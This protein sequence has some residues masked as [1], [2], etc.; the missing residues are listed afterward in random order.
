MGLNQLP[1]T[2]TDP[3]LLIA[4]LSGITSVAASN[5][6]P[7]YGQATT[8]HGLARRSDGTAWAWGKNDTGQLGNGT[9]DGTSPSSSYHPAP[10]QVLGIN[11]V[12]QVAAG[13]Q[14]S[15][16]LRNDGMVWAWGYN[17][18]GELGNGTTT[19]SDSPVQVSGLSGVV[20]IAA[21]SRFSLAL[22][23]DGT[24]W[25]WGKNDYGQL[26]DGTTTSRSSPVQVSG[27][28]GA[29]AVA[30]GW[31]HSLAL[32]SNG[33]VEAWG[34]N[35]SGQLGNGTTTDSH[36]PV[37]VSGLS[38]VVSLAAGSSYS[39]A[40]Q[41]GGTAWSWGDNTDGQLGNASFANSSL[42][43]QVSI[44]S[45]VV[46][47]G[48]GSMDPGFP[49]QSLG[50]ESLA[51][52]ALGTVWAWGLNND[53]QIGNGHPY[54]PGPWDYNTPQ[55][56]V[57]RS[58]GNFT[59]AAQPAG[60]G[61]GPQPG[62]GPTPGPGGQ[63]MLGFTPID[64]L[65]TSAYCTC[66]PINDATGNFFH[67]FT[68]VSIPGRGLPLS[69]VRTY[70]TLSASQSG[71]LG[72]G[73]TH[74]YNVFLT[75]DTSGNVTVH[76]ENGDLITFSP[77][78]S[79]Y[80]APSRVQGTLVKN[81]DGSF[82]LNRKN[83]THLTFTAAGQL[84]KEVDRN[85]YATNLAYQNN[86][87]S[88]VTDPSGRSLA[89]SY[90]SNGLLSQIVDP[91]SRKVSFAYDTN[92]NLTQVTDANSGVTKFTYD[93]AH[94]L[95]T[96]TDPNNGLLQNQYDS[97]GRIIKQIDPLNHVTTLSYQSGQTTVTHPN[98]NITVE[99][100]QNNALVLRT[101]GYGT[102]EA[103]SWSYSY[104]STS[105]GIT[106]VTDPNGRVTADTWD[107]SGNLLSAVD[108]LSRKT[109]YMYDSMNDLL[110]KTDALN[111]TTSYTYDGNGNL[112]TIA[113]PL[114]GTS[115]TATT[116][117]QYD[118]S[119]PGDAVKMTDPAGKLWQ[120]SYDQYGDRAKKVDP[121]TDTTTYAY[122]SVGRM[123]SEVSPR[124][125]ATGSNP[126]SYTTTY[127][128]DPLGDLTV[129]VDPLNHQTKN[130]YDPNR[131]LTSAA[132]GNN[133]ATNYTY[134]ADN[135]QTQITRAD[136]T[137]MKTAYDSNGNLG[138][139]TNGLNNAVSYKYNALNHRI[140]MTDP[141]NRITK[142]GYDGA[143]NR[144]SATDPQGRVT[145]YVYDGDNEVI[146]IAYGDGKTA[147]VSLSYDADGQ[148]L[149]MADGSGTSTYQFDSLHRVSQTKN[150]AGQT[151]QYGY[152]LNGHLSSVVY[153]G[154]SN[155]VTRG[156][157]DAGR[158]QSI[159]D[160]LHHT[161][162]FTYDPD[163]DLVSEGYPNGVAASFSY[164]AADRLMSITDSKGS[165]QLLSLSYT[166]D[167]ANQLT[168]E[169]SQTYAYNAIDQLTGSTLGKTT[170]SY[171]YSAA[172]DVTQAGTATMA[173][174]VADQLSKWS[175]SIKNF[176]TFAYDQDGNRASKTDASNN[177]TTYSFD[178][179]N[180]LTGYGSSAQYTY[181]GDG[182][183]A[184]KTVSGTSENF[185]W[186][187]SGSLPVLVQDG[188][189]SYLADDRGLPVEQITSSGALYY[190][191]QDQLGS[192]R[193]VTDSSGAIA[194]SYTYDAYGNVTNSTGSVANPF[195]YAGQYADSESKMV[196]LRA[197]YY[198]P[199]TEAFV[200]RDA[201]TAL[202]R[203]PY[204]Y[205]RDNPLD[206]SDPAGLG[207]VGFCVT[208]AAGFVA[209]GFVQGCVVTANL[210]EFGWT[211]THTI[212]SPGQGATPPAPANGYGPGLQTPSWSVSGQ[213]QASNADHVSDL[214][215]KFLY[216]GG[217]VGEGV[218]VGVGGFIGSSDCG[219]IVG[220]D[221]GV[222]L[223]GGLPA[224]VHGGYSWTTYGTF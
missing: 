186:D 90:G 139:Q 130:T 110:S 97:T 210:Q 12:I 6:L 216:A 211:V 113:T 133:Q 46:Q 80:Q 176:L 223:G 143:G 221:A 127:S 181:N 60:C 207:T 101:D 118:P 98:G 47:V 196:Y 214:G 147:A 34:R 24:V 201:A 18:D 164:D 64:E 167:S 20:A 137:T 4:N 5:G 43:V 105:L 142:Y 169:N 217:S 9:D 96:M 117:Y 208:F 23:S 70:N 48:T 30:A 66:Y 1:N 11:G 53:G 16:A 122:D 55:Q 172:D 39:L 93:S 31:F 145:S 157:D 61:T 22:K 170:T 72:Y 25:A 179:A 132:N 54:N 37:Q 125:N 174:D 129:V 74:S 108:P 67:L 183:R 193:L 213:V 76:E 212:D 84:T 57:S 205:V 219:P 107:A 13:A 79:S 104:D 154:G 8:G 199:S 14:H 95:L 42:P 85:G 151:L 162:T 153:P 17:G 83:Q 65:S 45:S 146:T 52:T 180:R 161:S 224:E 21:S 215:G 94:H 160:W 36:T 171:A 2:E 19:Q 50:G 192:T 100:Y 87:L 41:S 88:A 86:Q 195:Q 10:S 165:V 33:T 140:S 218:T 141:L 63:E 163:S 168:A 206:A 131:N 32:M 120:Y 159:T 222:G 190:F 68:D 182:L 81:G 71:P 166:R 135:E 62:I 202:T 203:E 3:P 173:Y 59:G 119:H 200:S 92:G 75:T 128:Y 178:E 191:Q 115:Q 152:D 69:F 136:G 116:A 103:A 91:A 158:L 177:V 144:T 58:G 106:S 209:G 15:L 188:T 185:A 111:V 204:V 155:T 198:D 56:M 77:N 73:W 121:L 35:Y 28:S 112:T 44:L 26:G 102:A 40:A 89:L 123:T 220:G 38:S 49:Q 27:L 149:S 175:T 114:V 7:A 197:R 51:V 134:D 29:Q 189:T 184:N 124:G 194:D 187:V 82:T 156:Y 150:G 126:A 109:T 78:G 138:S 148:R 99:Q